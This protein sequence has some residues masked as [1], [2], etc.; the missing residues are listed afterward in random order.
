MTDTEHIAKEVF[1]RDLERNEHL[2]VAVTAIWLI[3]AV[4][5][6]VLIFALN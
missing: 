3:V 4:L 5:V 6:V 2:S 1:A